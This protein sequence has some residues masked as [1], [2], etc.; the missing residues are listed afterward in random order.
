MI[1]L[2]KYDEESQEKIRQM[3]DETNT[4]LPKAEPDY[5]L[6]PSD[7]EQMD[8]LRKH[9]S[10]E[11]F[12]DDV[13]KLLDKAQAYDELSRTVNE[14]VGWV[15]TEFPQYADYSLLGLFNRLKKVLQEK[16]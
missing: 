11:Q 6:I 16:K 12:L 14:F 10:R 7:A 1:D 5:K 15:E 9:V 8:K 3:I 2:S 13:R 4:V